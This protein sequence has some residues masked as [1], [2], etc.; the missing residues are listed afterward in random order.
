MTGIAETKKRRVDYKM[1]LVDRIDRRSDSDVI[2]IVTPSD[3]MEFRRY[4]VYFE[5]RY[6]KNNEE[7]RNTDRMAIK[8]FLERQKGTHIDCYFYVAP[9]SAGDNGVIR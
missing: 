9:S 4:D 8:L 1:R 5:S 3:L 6:N 2:A 7:M